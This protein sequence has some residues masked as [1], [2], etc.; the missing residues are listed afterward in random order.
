MYVKNDNFINILIICNIYDNF[1]K[2]NNLDVNSKMEFISIFGVFFNVW[3]RN[4]F[5]SS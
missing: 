1:V 4:K 5:V 2:E 3:C